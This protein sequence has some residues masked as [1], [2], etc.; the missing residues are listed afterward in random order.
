MREKAFKV[1]K[2]FPCSGDGTQR[3]SNSHLTLSSAPVHLY[4]DCNL[5]RMLRLAVSLLPDMNY[6]VFTVTCSSHLKVLL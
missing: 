6:N 3:A 4:L 5:G 2:I 1:K